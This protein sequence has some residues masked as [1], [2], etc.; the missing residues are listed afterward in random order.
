MRKN[1]RRVH[2]PL[3]LERIM[4]TTDFPDSTDIEGVATNGAITFRMTAAKGVVR[5]L[6]VSSALSVV[7]IFNSR[8]AGIPSKHWEHA[9]VDRIPHA[10]NAFRPA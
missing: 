1:T 10:K 5:L 2:A 3:N 9:C 4:E 7:S 6:S 8:I